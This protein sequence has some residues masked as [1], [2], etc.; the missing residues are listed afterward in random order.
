MPKDKRLHII[1]LGR[2][3]SGKGTQADLLIKRFDLHRITTGELLRDLAKGKAETSSRVRDTIEGGSLVPHWLVSYL[4]I[5][6]IIE[7]V[8][9]RS[10]I[11]FDGSPRR[12]DEAELLLDVLAWHNRRNCKVILVEI[13]E[14]EAYLRLAK[15]RICVAC[16]KLIPYLDPW[17]YIKACDACGGEL[18][19]RSDD[20][21]RSIRK[22]LQWYNKEERPLVGLFEKK[23]KLARINGEQPI[24]Q[25][26]EDIVRALS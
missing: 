22:R 15:R 12:I 17:K 20:T 10:G 4:W 9:A 13:S 26:F 2:S 25:V 11:L 18:T 8:P 3:G 24:S 19:T 16:G 7:R 14:K 6:E 21:P 1:L 5:R 23:K